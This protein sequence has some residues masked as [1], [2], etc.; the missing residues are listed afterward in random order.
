MSCLDTFSVF[1]TTTTMCFIFKALCPNCKFCLI[2]K[3]WKCKKENCSVADEI[4]NFSFGFCAN[5][6]QGE[7][8]RIRE[9]LERVSEIYFINRQVQIK[10]CK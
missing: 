2:E 6:A 4:N 8:Q 10:E 3:F 5:C 7:I 1:V 9:N